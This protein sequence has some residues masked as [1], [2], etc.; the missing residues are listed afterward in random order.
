MADRREGGVVCSSPRDGLRPSH[1]A[2]LLSASGAPSGGGRVGG[3]VRRLD[4]T[5]SGSGTQLPLAASRSSGVTGHKTRLEGP[6]AAGLA[7]DAGLR[8]RGGRTCRSR[9]G[10]CSTSLAAGSVGAAR[11]VASALRLAGPTGR[12]P[13]AS[14]TPGV[15]RR[16]HV[17]RARVRRDCGGRGQAPSRSPWRNALAQPALDLLQAVPGQLGHPE[18]DEDP[19]RDVEARVD[20][21]GR[22]R[23][24]SPR[25][26][27]ARSA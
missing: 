1:V 26:W 25:S 12:T 15:A 16:R 13:P 23:R 11:L 19:G 6:Q 3:A 24:R 22:A 4:A 21:H 8:L 2:D 20:P 10:C 5:F 17:G 18:Q 27:S 14:A 9:D 7:L